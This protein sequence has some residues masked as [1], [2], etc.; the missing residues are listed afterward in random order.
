MP[1]DS[2][3]AEIRPTK[4][5][6]RAAAMPWHELVLLAFVAAELLFFDVTGRRFLTGDNLANILRHSTELGLLALAMMPVILTGGIDLSIG[7]LL[8][9]SAVLFGKMVDEGGLSPLCAGV[10]TF[11]AGAAAGGLNALLIGALRL[12]PLIVTLGTYS[13][14]RGLAEALTKGTE[15][16]S[17]FPPYFLAFG[18]SRIGPLPAQGWILA[19]AAILFWILVHKTVLGRCWRAIGYSPEGAAHAGIAV[20][21]RVATAYIIAGA[22]SALAAIVYTA[23]VAQGRADAGAGYELAAIT[24]VVLGGSSIFGGSGSVPGTVLGVAAI[25]L[26]SNGLGRIPAAMGVSRELAGMM[27]GALLLA[28]LSASA[29]A[30]MAS[31]RRARRT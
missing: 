1:A 17:R 24:A 7:S 3:P 6:A 12:P 23:R 11:L 4:A 31:E 10:I 29:L 8:G 9:L 30:R 18:N 21:T 16:Y 5:A 22:V 15:I 26:L 20:K 25:A 2:M 19:A 14:F 28:A 27:T 13:L